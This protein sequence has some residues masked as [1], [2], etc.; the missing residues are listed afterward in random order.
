MIFEWTCDS[1]QTISV[2]EFL[3]SRQ[4]PRRFITRLKFNQGD[5]QINGQSVTVRAHL[6]QGDRL[7][8]IAPDENGHDTVIPSDAPIDIVYEDRDLLV[9]NKPTNVVSIPSKRNPDSAMANRIKGYY[10]RQGYSDQVIHIVTRLD[11]NTTGLML[12]AKH[13]LAHAWMD[14]QIRQEM[15]KKYYYAISH[16]SEWPQHGFIDGPIARSEASIIT[17]KVDPSGQEALTEFWLT[18]R[19]MD[20]ALL[21]IR[22]YTGRT[23]QIRVHFAHMGGPLVGDDLYGGRIEAPLMRQALHC[24]E[25]QFIQP[26]TQEALVI[27]QT[28]PMD[29]VEWMRQR[30]I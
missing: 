17:R 21:R 30:N 24:G 15:L 11:R 10:L 2:I 18:D 23:H 13:R 19:M 8:L 16:R 6:S 28:L 7:T 1:N 25:L 26:F 4:V 3:R 9:V 20:S 27:K 12:I 29:M 5:I 14:Q 22:L